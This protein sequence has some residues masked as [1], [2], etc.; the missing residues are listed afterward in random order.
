VVQYTNQRVSTKL[1]AEHWR[2]AGVQNARMSTLAAESRANAAAV[3]A[4]VYGR[5][6]G[7]AAPLNVT[8]LAIKP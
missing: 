5:V 8:E 1:A 4:E 6:P 2:K 3:A 7:P